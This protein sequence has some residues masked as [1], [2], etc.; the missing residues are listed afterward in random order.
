MRKLL[1]NL[2]KSP[3]SFLLVLVP[4][5]ISSTLQANVEYAIPLSAEEHQIGNM[6][7]WATAFEMNN[8]MFVVEKSSDGVSYQNI[9]AVDAA[10]Q[11]ETGQ[12]YRFLDVNASERKAFYRLKQL[13][14]DGTASY[15]VTVLVK[16][17]IPNQFMV[18]SMSNTSTDKLF[19]LTLDAMAEGEL[20]YRVKSIQ[21]NLVVEGSQSL[22]Q[23]LND[24]QFDLE[25]EPE[26]IYKIELQ[27]GEEQETLVIS[28][29]NDD[30]LKKENV[31]SKKPANGG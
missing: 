8:Q 26:G 7:Q 23:G 10:G 5:F 31:A 15:S 12:G 22:F 20:N 17:S 14:F 29:V 27:K 19:E 30:L 11:T 18:V 16:R 25:D 3:F 9:G 24:L 1:Q 2:V 28:K 4:L 13:D 6:L 21:G